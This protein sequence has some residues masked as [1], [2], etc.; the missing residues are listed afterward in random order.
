MRAIAQTVGLDVV[1]LHGHETP[2]VAAA[3]G[4]RIVKALGTRDG[5]VSG[6]AEEWAADVLLLIDAVDPERRGGTGVLA[7]WSAAAQLAARR[8]IVLAG[9]LTPANVA[10][11][12]DT[13]HPYAVDVASGVEERP[14]VKDVRRMRAFMDAVERAGRVD[15]ADVRVD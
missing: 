3:V 1:Q 9:G 8:A 4:R 10:A 14:G 6:A 15:R 11:A 7:D 13:V 5:D 12:I 2:D